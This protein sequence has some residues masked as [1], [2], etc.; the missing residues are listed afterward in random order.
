MRTSSCSAAAACSRTTTRST[1]PRCT[2]FPRA[3]SRSSRSSL[4]LA[5][6]LGLPVAVLGQGVGPLRHDDAKSITAE[7]FERASV[8]S[9]RDAE[10]MALLRDLGVERP[11]P[12]APDPAWTCFGRFGAAQPPGAHFPALAGRPVMAMVLRDW[13]FDEAWEEDFATAFRAAL[14]APWGL[15]W[16]DFTRTP[17][18]SGVRRSG[19][20]IAHRMMP[21]LPGTAH[22]VWEGMR[23]AEAAALLAGAD[24]CVAMRLHGALLA[25]LAGVPTVALEYDGKVRALGDELGVPAAQRMPLRDIPARLGA[26]VRAVTGA[27]GGRPF[28]LDRA[29]AAGLAS[30][31]LMHRDL[32]WK[33][34]A[35]S[36]GPHPSRQRRPG[37][38]LLGEWLV[39]DPAA[40]PRV[41]DALLRRSAAGT[42]S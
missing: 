19:S 12:C 34:M 17:D 23:V 16:L 39:H 27:E 42:R 5:G 20:E 25:H 35:A 26:G 24:A 40:T 22:A 9:V 41:I 36:R 32:L 14:P 11:I 15:L 37:P 6:E 18:A 1:S 13:P 33:A 29:V 30:S 38:S 8:A 10:S 4:F 28:R 7:V 2:A 3:T 31:A 21:R